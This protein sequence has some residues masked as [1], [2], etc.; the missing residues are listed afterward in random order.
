MTSNQSPIFSKAYKFIVWLINHTEKFPRSERFRLARRLDDSAF[1]FYELLMES[2][3]PTRTQVG[4]READMELDRLR[5][6]LRLS[7]SRGLL[8]VK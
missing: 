8:N 4:L 6:Y 1:N 3:H 5:F 2:T 7:Y